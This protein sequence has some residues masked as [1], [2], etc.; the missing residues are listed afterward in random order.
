[1]SNVAEAFLATV[2]HRL[3]VK[4]TMIGISDQEK[5]LLG[6]IGRAG[7]AGGVWIVAHTEVAIQDH[8]RRLAVA[9]EEALRIEGVE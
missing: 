8:V 5:V 9:L 4:E 2:A 3:Q 1:M 7:A 6:R